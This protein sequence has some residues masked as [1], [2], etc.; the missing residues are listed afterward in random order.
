MA[1]ILISTTNLTKKYGSKTVVDNVSIN[2]E[3]GGI[4]GLVGQ[5]GAGKTTLIR[6]L[7]GLVAPTSGSFALM[8]SQTRAPHDVAAIVE[9]PSIYSNMSAMDNLI[10]QC[11]LLG[12]DVDKNYLANT[13]SIVGLDET[14]TRSVKDYS[15]G[16]KQRLAIAMT[17]VGKPQLLIL[18]EPTN[19]LD[20][21]G[22]ADMREVFVNLNQSLGVTIIISSHILSEL[23]KFATEFY[24]MDAG[25]IL[26]RVSADEI[27]NV[28]GK[29]I[30]LYV[31][32]AEQAIAALKD[33]G[34][35]QVCGDGQV[36]LSTEQPIT[37][38]MLTLSQAGVTVTNFV[39]AGDALEDYYL[40]ILREAHD[41]FF[42]AANGG[43]L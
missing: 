40:Q 37:Q 6:M 12:L 28:N 21:Q 1:D 5:N 22:I 9:K 26:K 18:D 33:V 29:R 24:I 31:Q 27:K 36:M 4:I 39:Q 34:N 17:L 41:P 8:P 14:V 16:M 13:L 2:I 15:L 30:R 35:A 38:I 32:D 23:G 19:G 3:R 43:K 10:A 20:P 7:T 25:K 42:S 11:M